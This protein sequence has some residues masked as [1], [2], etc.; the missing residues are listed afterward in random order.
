[1]IQLIILVGRLNLYNFTTSILRSVRSNTF[2]L[3]KECSSKCNAVAITSLG[4]VVKHVYQRLGG[5]IFALPVPQSS[6]KILETPL[7]P[8]QS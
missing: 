7:S 4:P 2:L 5:S 1:M 3:I 6:P 8:V